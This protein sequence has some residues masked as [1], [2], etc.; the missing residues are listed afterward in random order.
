VAMD[1]KASS[2]GE[3]RIGGFRPVRT[4]HLGVTSIVI[5]V[6][7]E[8]SGKKFALKQLLE[9]RAA[10]PSERRA[11]EAEA[12]LGI[13]LHHPN[14]VRYHELI[15]DPEGP[16]IV[17]DYFPGFHLKHAVAKPNDYPSLRANLHKTITQA[18]Q[19]LA[20]MHDQGWIHRDIKPENIMANKTGEVRVIDYTLTQRP[21]S[22]ISGLFKKKMKVRQGTPS[23]ISPEQ[24][25]LATPAV[26]ADIYS[27][28]ATCYELAC[29]RPPFR[30]NSTSELLGKH[31]REQPSP[32]TMHNKD[33]TPE[34]SDLIL[35]TLKKKPADRPADLREFLSRFA[36][37]RVCKDDPPPLPSTDGFR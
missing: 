4:L 12:R 18:A 30:A 22:G 21:V 15:R 11:F 35:Q 17:M 24:I 37:V 23:Y 9:S 26:A 19:G 32:P 10:D 1:I 36:R 14:L 13:S 3:D 31:V 16:Y 20:Y 29:G 2:T 8:S 7:Q 6:V 28:G 25:Q 34:F 27:F 5:E 33:I